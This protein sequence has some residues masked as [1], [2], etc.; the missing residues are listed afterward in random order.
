LLTVPAAL[1]LQRLLL[2]PI[3]SQQFLYQSRPSVL[4]ARK[5]EDSLQTKK[6]IVVTKVP[7]QT[8]QALSHQWCTWRGSATGS[9]GSLLLPGI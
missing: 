1:E 6:L 2:C 7:L 5:K 8:T 4:P 3:F 9:T